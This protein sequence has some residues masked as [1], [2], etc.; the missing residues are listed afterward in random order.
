MKVEQQAAAPFTARPRRVSPE[1]T[2]NTEWTRSQHVAEII[3]AVPGTGKVAVSRAPARLDL[4]G[5]SSAH[6]GCLTLSATLDRYA[7]VA[8]RQRDD[9]KVL[10]RRVGDPARNGH[11]SFE[12]D[13]SALQNG[14]PAAPIDESECEDIP[15]I[16]SVLRAL[17]EEP[18]A[19][20]CTGG[21]S[22]TYGLTMDGIAGDVGGVA[23]IAVATML[24]CAAS[25]QRTLSTKD[26]CGTVERMRERPAAQ[27]GADVAERPCAALSVN[28]ALLAATG[29]PR[30]ILQVRSDPPAPAGLLALPPELAVAGIDCGELAP[31]ATEKWM[32][33]MTSSRIGAALIERISRFE[34]K[35]GEGLAYLSRVS[36][37][38]FVDRYRDRLP[39]R[40]KGADFLQG[41]PDGAAY[42]GDI[43]PGRTYKV[44]SRTEHH[45][46][47]HDRALKFSQMLSRA[48]R[49]GEDALL[50]DAGAL[51]NA[52]HWSYGQRCALG[53]VAT[54]TLVKLLGLHG[55]GS[56]VYGAKISGRGCGGVVAVLL[57]ND[58][59]AFAA[60]NEAVEDYHRQTGHRCTLMHSS[61]PG[62]LLTGA[63]LV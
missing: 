8:V 55:Q 28:D 36:V 58:E 42:Q 56:G 41:F 20:G 22:L 4:M 33:A 32:Q 48:F 49:T 3:R 10:L 1:I 16:L 6:H 35:K 39:R 27:E 52:T 57:R 31:R 34:G 7:C 59:S 63:H 44:R 45:V 40:I 21:F 5:G 17:R 19:A 14:S 53:N 51:M 29:E 50:T 60:V 54:D 23:A 25:L 37:S 61:L 47:E 38:D 9:G 12:Y 15:V 2:P 18:W 43:E 30:A 62:A 11:A 13:E 24:A 46:Y 26:I